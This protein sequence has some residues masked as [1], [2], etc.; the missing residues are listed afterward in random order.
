MCAGGST[1]LAI[2]RI[3]R[4]K[5]FRHAM[6]RRGAGGRATRRGL[7]HDAATPPG[8]VLDVAAGHGL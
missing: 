1:G 6:V 3:I 4:S 5:V 2:R 7:C 8:T